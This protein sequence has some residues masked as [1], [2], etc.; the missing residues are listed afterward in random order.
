MV[1]EKIQRALTLKKLREAAT[2]EKSKEMENVANTD[3]SRD[4]QKVDRSGG[5]WKE[6]IL[7]L[8]NPPAAY[9]RST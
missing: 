8:Q 7:E 6:R 3:K 2:A 4:K 5:P 1:M 9:S